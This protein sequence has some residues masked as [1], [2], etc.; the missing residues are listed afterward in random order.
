M[1]A[2]AGSFPAWEAK[3]DV[4]LLIGLLVVGYLV[5]AVHLG[6]RLS[7]AGQPVVSRFQMVAFGLGVVAVWVAADYPVDVIAEESLYSVHVVQHL[8]FALVAAPLLVLGTPGWL[9]RWILT[10]RWLFVTVRF[11]AR[12]LPAVILYNLVLVIMSWPAVVEITVENELAHLVGHAVVLVTALVV[13][14]PVLSPLPEIPRLVPIGR[15]VFLFLESLVPTIPA[16][17]LT[18]GSTP[19]YRVYDGLPLVWGGTTLQD[20]RIAGLIMKLGAGLVIWA[21]ITVVFFR[22]ATDEERADRTESPPGWQD[23]SHQLTATSSRSL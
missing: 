18:F 3:P 7:P 2:A 21:V 16:S 10:P 4:W 5:A 6:P 1:L 14:L 17:F 9:M 20:Q 15:M 12:F 13:W 8:L 11:L 19:L 23:L 22:W